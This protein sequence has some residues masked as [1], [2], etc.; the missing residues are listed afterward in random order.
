M[1]LP[2]AWITGAG[3]LIGSHLVQT[4]AAF[5]PGF[6]VRPLTRADLDL[7]DANAVRRLFAQERPS[8]VLHCAAMSRIAD[9]EENPAL[10]ERVNVHA[11]RVL[12]ELSAGIP[13]VFLSTD[14]VFDGRKGSYTETDV[15]GPLN[16]YAATK[17]R[18]ESAVLANPLH[19]VVRLSLNAGASPRGDK[20]FTEDMRRAWERGQTLNLFTDEFR[21]PLPAPVTA[22][23][24]WEL[25]L[26]NR[27]GIHHLAGAERLSRWEIGEL[28]AARWTHLNPRMT[29]TSLK[30]YRGP[31]RA[32][33]TTLDCRKLQALLTFPL[34][35]FSDWLRENPTAALTAPAYFPVN[36][37][38]NAS[39]S[40]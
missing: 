38:N 21:N 11:T 15:V 9:C 16:P 10:A 12:G 19:T 6:H 13:F 29:P 26:L 14:L 5:A 35:R 23:A 2:L 31:A 37:S 33:D 8:L 24:L 25:A 39:A 1:S 28:L 17:T 34:P 32:P 40:R 3:G 18:A 27:P 4:A 36:R 22:R 20:S 30:D 7:T